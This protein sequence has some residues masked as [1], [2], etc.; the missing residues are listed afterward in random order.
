[1]WIP[2][3]FIPLYAILTTIGIGLGLQGFISF[4][5]I[6]YLVIVPLVVAPATYRNLVSGGCSLRF[7]ICALVKGMTAGLLFLIMAFAFDVLLWGTFSGIIGVNLSLVVLRVPNLYQIWLIGGI[8]GGIG[9]RVIEVREY[10][11][12][13]EI[14][15]AGYK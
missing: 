10:S 7:Q 11:G 9:A 13:P 14:T 5:W 6:V 3:Y 1:L 2:K 8:I 4:Y 12:H 15:I